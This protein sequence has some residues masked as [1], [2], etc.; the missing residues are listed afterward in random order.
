MAH[1]LADIARSTAATTLPGPTCSVRREQARHPR[2][3]EIAEV[4]AD[5]TITAGIAASIFR[6]AGIDISRGTV[7]RHRA[8]D[9]TNCKKHGVRW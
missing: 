2:G 7:D 1:T 4:I 8:N 3:A 6:D 5:R 9:C